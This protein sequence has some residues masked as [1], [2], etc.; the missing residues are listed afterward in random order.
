M[1][2]NPTRDKASLWGQLGRYALARRLLTVLIVVVLVGLVYTA[3]KLQPWMPIGHMVHLKSTHLGDFDFEI[4]QRKG[5]SIS[6]PFATALFVR[7]SG[8]P[9]RV[10][11]LGFEDVYRP[12]IDLRTEG[13]VVVVFYGNYRYAYFDE[14]QQVLRRDSKDQ[15]LANH[16]VVIDSDPPGDWWHRLSVER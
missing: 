11:L 1:N 3:W 8:E 9:W 15:N 13:A 16:G 4:W 5:A 2:M 12:R 7:K 14:Q 10:Y 6:E